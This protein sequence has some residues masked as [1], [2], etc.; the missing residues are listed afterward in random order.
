M[1]IRA[2]D[3][4]TAGVV[5]S[6][7]GR[8]DN[9]LDASTFAIEPP[10][11]LPLWRPPPQGAVSRLTRRPEMRPIAAKRRHCNPIWPLA[12]CAPA[13]ATPGNEFPWPRRFGV[14][15]LIA[16][17]SIVVATRPSTFRVERSI[18][19]AAPPE[20]VFAQVNDFHA[21]DAWSPWA[22]LDPQMKTT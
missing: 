13:G 12:L 20:T 9:R 17:L 1:V 19:V 15:A 16:V 7:S 2:G 10:L 21:W 14:V 18:A 3:D 6:P 11:N 5:L 4:G 22:K 8:S